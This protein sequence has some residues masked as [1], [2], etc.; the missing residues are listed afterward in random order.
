MPFSWMGKGQKNFRKKILISLQYLGARVEAFFVDGK[1]PLHV[2]DEK[3]KK[4]IQ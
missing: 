3:T 4:S 1:Q 2:A